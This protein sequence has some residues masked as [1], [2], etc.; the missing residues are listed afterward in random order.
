MTK[1]QNP[2]I[3]DLE[4][5]TLGFAKNVRVFVRKLSK[6]P[7]N[8]EDGKQPVKASG[9]VGANYIEANEALSKKDFT[10]RIKICR[11]EAKESR[12]WLKLI[13]TCSEME[14]ENER[15]YLEKEAQNL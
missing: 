4:D 2:R 14:R 5:R 7:I 1:T 8:N 10:T 3:Y 9:P 6:T 13:D 12:Y 15:Q 11:K